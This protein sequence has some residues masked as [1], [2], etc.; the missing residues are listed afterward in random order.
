MSSGANEGDVLLGR[1]RL[2]RQLGA[3]GPSATWL[4]EDV[5]LGEPVVLRILAAELSASHLGHERLRE[6]CRVARRLNHPNIARVHDFHR[7]GELCFVSREYVESADA[8]E[9]GP[10]RVHTLVGVVDAV[11][12]AH[13]LGVVHGDLKPSKLI[14]DT[15]GV[16]RLADFRIAAELRAV[17]RA[18]GPPTDEPGPC[19]ATAADDIHALGAL[20][21]ELLSGEPLDAEAP[22]DASARLRRCGVDADLA[23]VIERMLAP[24][25]DDRP[26]AAHVR[27]A[28]EPGAVPA[29][30]PPREPATRAADEVVIPV[31]VRSP[32]EVLPQLRRRATHA[33]R[34]PSRTLALA[35][36]LLLTIAVGVFFYLP[37]WVESR[38][39][40]EPAVQAEH[41]APEAGGS[42][43]A[44]APPA[45]E[46]DAKKLLAEVMDLQETLQG[47]QVEQWAP[48]EIGEIEQLV[49]RGE[50]SQLAGDPSQAADLFG[51]ARDRLSALE[52]RVPQVLGEALAAGTTALESGDDE[53]A[54][55]SFQRALA[56]DPGNQEAKAGLARAE[57]LDDVTAL[58]ASATRFEA[59]GKLAEARDAYARAL[60]V[61][62]ASVRARE[63]LDRVSAQLSEAQ[64][65]RSM[66]RATQ[67]LARG[68]LDEAAREAGAALEARPGSAEAK[69][70]RAR[71]RSRQTQNAVTRHLN[72]ATRQEEAGQWEAAVASYRA[73]LA[74]EPEL[75]TA[76]SGLA[77]SEERARL[78]SQLSGWIADPNRLMDPGARDEAGRVV[79]QARN[80]PDAS[81][82]FGAQLAE[83]ERLL[84]AF[85][86]PVTVVF[87]SDNET[88]V[89]I[90]R[91]QK[92]GS[93]TRREVELDPGTYVVTG[94]RR[95]YRDVRRTITVT[96][97][98]APAPVSIRCSQPI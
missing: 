34:K 64:Y 32:D 65:S 62:S 1:F 45:S 27:A 9:P 40:A 48:Q 72:D 7:E 60:E 28:F 14:W 61:D 74:L 83:V 89:T 37:T 3:D 82:H 87:E 26:P 85:S 75:A 88:E 51:R 10:E 12:Y 23:E 33:P 66:A 19:D 29:W 30:T 56:I 55:E 22:P 59:D 81:D 18:L 76:R 21:F 94:M 86:R 6:A 43:A 31:P 50:K 38:D 44:P 24:A 17:G 69:E 41:D 57:R 71:I 90:Q 63:G 20:L 11:A 97:G 42:E 39:R 77:R 58:V 52:D 93:F 16:P 53:G 67:A 8:P 70:L 4:A 95:G 91:L 36:G 25:A 98:Q 13:G 35:F 84:A 79:A 47:K 5:E 15:A 49:E 2:V 80:L 73:A 54:V 92:L 46:A 78:A 96:P 68:A